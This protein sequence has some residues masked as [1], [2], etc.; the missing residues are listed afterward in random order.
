MKTQ[1]KVSLVVGS[2]LI[3]YFLSAAMAESVGTKDLVGKKICWVLSAA[4]YNPPVSS[5][6]STYSAGGKY[7]DTYW[8]AGTFTV[9]AQGF[10]AVTGIGILDAQI[11]KLPD[12]TFKSTAVCSAQGNCE[13]GRG[14]PTFVSTGRY[15]K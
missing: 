10:H 5:S 8:G 4:S 11:E 14:G 7:Y 3:T 12:G 1:G 9:T 2:M 15:C 13:A 6:T